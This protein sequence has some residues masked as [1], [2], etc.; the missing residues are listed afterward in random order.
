MADNP[1][2]KYML[3]KSKKNIAMLSSGSGRKSRES[4]IRGGSKGLVATVT[5]LLK[6]IFIKMSVL[7]YEPFMSLA[8]VGPI[9]EL[10]KIKETQ[11]VDFN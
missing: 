5:K 10:F 1:L 3:E 4:K 6:V 7:F 8:E 2:L 11:T 9:L